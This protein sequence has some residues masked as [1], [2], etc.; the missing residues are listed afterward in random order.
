[1]SSFYE[2]LAGFSKGDKDFALCTVVRVKGSAPRKTGAKMVVFSDGIIDGTIGGGDVEKNV[3][4]NALS[5]IRTGKPELFRHDLLH[6]HSMC[7]GGTMEIF[8]EPVMKRNLLYIFGA[9]H[10]GIALA[11]LAAGL[12]FDIVIIDDRREYIDACEIPGVNKMNLSYKVA[13]PVIPFNDRTYIC[14]MTYSHQADREILAYCVKKPHA[15]LGMIGS[16]RKT[17]LTRKIFMEAGIPAGEIGDVDMPMGIDI[18]AEGPEEI[19]ISVIG[20][21]I[22]VKNKMIP[23]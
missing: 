12:D 4:E 8:I 10:T 23:V 5:A 22:E 14:I 13:L 21:I 17:E 18:G 3:I 11:R 15:Y 20:K 2:K 9:G 7:C 16:R 1:V 19:A 6:Q